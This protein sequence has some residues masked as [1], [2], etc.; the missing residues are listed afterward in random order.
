MVNDY[1]NKTSAKAAPP[2]KHAEL[3]SGPGM[4]RGHSSLHPKDPALLERRLLVEQVEQE[5]LQFLVRD[6]LGDDEGG[7]R[8]LAVVAHGQ[9]GPA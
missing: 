4:S 7:R 5:L 3:T 1:A 6:E 8:P 2:F 9:R